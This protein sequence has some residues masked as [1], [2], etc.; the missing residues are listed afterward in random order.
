[1]LTDGTPQISISN[2]AKLHFI[3]FF[4]FDVLAYRDN[5]YV[6]VKISA[7][8]EHPELEG[9]HALIES[10]YVSFFVES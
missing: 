10:E 2:S 3:D 4:N 5:K 1:V 7:W 8:S 6:Q 9:K